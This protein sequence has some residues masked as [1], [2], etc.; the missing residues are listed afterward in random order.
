MAKKHKIKEFDYLRFM[1]NSL[2]GGW[3][4]INH[5]RINREE[6]QEKA[7]IVYKYMQ[8]PT[9]IEGKLLVIQCRKKLTKYL[10]KNQETLEV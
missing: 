5:A 9:Q 8:Y 6:N 3:I 4:K 7:N 1:E 10:E 2:S